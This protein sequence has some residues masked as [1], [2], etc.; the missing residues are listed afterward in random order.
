MKRDYTKAALLRSFTEY[1][2]MG[3]VDGYGENGHA[4][5]WVIRTASDVEALPANLIYVWAN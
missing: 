3:R 4:G 1:H 5:T 2:G